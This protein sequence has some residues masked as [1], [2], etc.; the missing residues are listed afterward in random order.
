MFKLEFSTD[1]DAFTID[2]PAEIA[3]ILR[4]VADRIEVS[5]DDR[6]DGGAFFLFSEMTQS[7]F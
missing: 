5:A 1:N 6:Y 2:A 3:R 4:V 7:S